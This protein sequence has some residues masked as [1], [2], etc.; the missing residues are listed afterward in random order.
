MKQSCE[1]LSR[2]DPLTI[3]KCNYQAIIDEMD[4]TK[5]VVIIAGHYCLAKHM[6]ELSSTGDAE[7][8]GFELGVQLY[9]LAR[10]KN[11]HY[12]L[13][14]WINDIGID[15]EKRKTYKNT[16]NLPKNYLHI[17]A[18][19]GLH[20]SIVHIMFESNMRNRAST[21]VRKI[22]KRHPG[23]LRKVNANAADLVRCVKNNL[24]DVMQHDN[25]H[26]YVITGPEN[27]Q[28]VVKEGPSPKCNLILA[29]FFDVLTKQYQPMHFINI[30]NDIYAYRLRLGV[31]VAQ[32][33]LHNSV[34]MTNVLCD[35]SS[36]RCESY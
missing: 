11:Q 22:V 31:H 35:G 8:Q 36:I 24:C 14:V 3:F 34:A 21:L 33:L 25:R 28:L 20:P 19:Y 32:N 12:H 6:Q 27:E 17:L 5:P 30:F 26:A 13:V 10:E 1:K 29:T 15:T 7:T 16:N 23:L 9:L 4:N 2:C 18:S